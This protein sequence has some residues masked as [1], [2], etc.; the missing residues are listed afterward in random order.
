MLLNDCVPW[1]LFEMVSFMRNT[2]TIGKYSM[3]KSENMNIKKNQAEEHLFQ[4]I[5]QAGEDARALFYNILKN[6]KM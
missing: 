5:K 1:G 2:T 4:L 3:T 6:F